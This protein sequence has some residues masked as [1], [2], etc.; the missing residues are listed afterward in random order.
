M[1]QEVVGHRRACDGFSRVAHAVAPDSWSV[2]TPCAEWT[3]RDVVEHVIGFH[4]FLLL[5]PLGVRARR[6]RDDPAA[7]WSA[8]SLA[9][10]T[11][12]A[13]PGVLDRATELPGGGGSTPRTMIGAL[14]TDVLVH[15]WDLA[16]AVRQTADLD[17]ELCARA[18]AGAQASGLQRHEAMIGPEVPIGTDA[19]LADR[20]VA[21]YGRDPEW[22]P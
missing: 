17:E 14:T 8:T 1:D 20:L 16:R 12:L 5:R 4:E 9:L 19:A 18:Y 3:A 10:F 2:P 7:R 13:T 6:P 22:A 21:F 15:T 11:A